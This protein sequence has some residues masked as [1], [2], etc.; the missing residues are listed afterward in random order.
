M[1]GRRRDRASTGGGA[2]RTIEQ[3]NPAYYERVQQRLRLWSAPDDSLAGV[4]TSTANAIF[5]VGMSYFDRMGDQRA[6]RAF[7]ERFGN[8]AAGDMSAAD[9]MIDYLAAYD[10]STQEF[11]TTLLG[12][13]EDVAGRP[14]T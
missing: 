6:A 5:N 9:Q 14:P 4:A 1:F 13:L 11:L 7:D 8:R 12:R 2:V 10:A 3:L